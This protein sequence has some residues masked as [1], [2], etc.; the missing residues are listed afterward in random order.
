MSDICGEGPRVPRH[1]RSYTD[2]AALRRQIVDE[3]IRALTAFRS[4]VRAGTFPGHSEIVS[5][6]DDEFSRFIAQLDPS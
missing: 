2:I 4:D 6:D 3:R 1:A 5:I